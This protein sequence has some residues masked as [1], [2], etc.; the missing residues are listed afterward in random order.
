MAVAWVISAVDHS[1]VLQNSIVL[2]TLIETAFEEAELNSPFTAS[3]PFDETWEIASRPPREG[4]THLLAI[5]CEQQIVGGFFSIDTK[6]ISENSDAECGWFF[7][8]PDQPAYLRKSIALDLCNV[9]HTLMRRAG[10]QRVVTM[11]GTKAGERFLQRYFGYEHQPIESEENRCV[12]DLRRK[13]K[14]SATSEAGVE[15]ALARSLV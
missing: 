6:C 3:T 5:N 13:M 7:V 2:K 8:M 12:Y 15:E 11:I 4:I 10:Y 9:A 14:N 1:Y